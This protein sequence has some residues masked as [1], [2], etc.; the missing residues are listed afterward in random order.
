MTHT[1]LTNYIRTYR[2]RA[3]LSQDDVA[4]LFKCK[5]GTK[6]SR[7]ELGERIPSV[8][9][10]LA[11]ELVLGAPVA[12]LFADHYAVLRKSISDR[13]TA[14]L[15][16]LETDARNYAEKCERLA[17]LAHTA[18]PLIIPVCDE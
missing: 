14:L 13:A 3:H 6:I 10:A 16:S 9:T 8:Q 15:E 11:Y 17:A 7:H 5:S 2:K 4:F 12:T 1:Q 18:E